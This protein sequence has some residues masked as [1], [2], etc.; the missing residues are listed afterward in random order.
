MKI[1][2]NVFTYNEANKWFLCDAASSFD[3]ATHSHFLS[4][5]NLDARLSHFDAQIGTSFRRHQ[6]TWLTR[7]AERTQDD[8]K[9]KTKKKKDIRCSNW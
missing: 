4:L 1:K 7:D 2:W 6:R 9:W 3:A 8:Q 5:F